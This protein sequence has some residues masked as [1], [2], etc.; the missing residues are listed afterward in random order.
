MISSSD[1]A[2]Q[3]SSINATSVILTLAFA[4]GVHKLMQ[5][6]K[7]RPEGLRIAIGQGIEAEGTTRLC[8]DCSKEG[9]EHP[10]ELFTRQ[11]CC[12]YWMCVDCRRMRQAKGFC[13]EC[14]TKYPAPYAYALDEVPACY[15]PA[16]KYFYNNDLARFYY[17]LGRIYAIGHHT[18]FVEIDCLPEYEPVRP[19]RLTFLRHLNPMDPKTA[20]KFLTLSAEYEYIPAQLALG[21]LYDAVYHDPSSAEKWYRRALGRGKDVSPLAF[22]RYGLFLEQQG[23][24]REAKMLFKDAAQCG[25]AHAQFEYARMILEGRSGDTGILSFLFPRQAAK[26]NHARR[27]EAVKWLCSASEKGFYFRSYILLAKTL[28][29]IAEEKHGRADIVGKSPLPRAFQML[30]LAKKHPQIDREVPRD[31]KEILK[32]IDDILDPYEEGVRRRCATCGE[33][34]TEA[35]PLI[36]CEFCGIMAYC[37]KLCRKKHYRDGHCFDCCGP[38]DLFRFNVNEVTSFDISTVVVTGSKKSLRRMVDDFT[39]EVMEG[40]DEDY[41]SEHLCRLMIKMRRNLEKY[42]A[43]KLQDNGKGTLRNRIKKF[44]EKYD[45]S[46]EYAEALDA[47]RLLGNRGAHKDEDGIQPLTHSEC[48][49]AVERFQD[50]RTAFASEGKHPNGQPARTAGEEEATPGTGDSAY[51]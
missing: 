7:S 48:Q 46:E 30:Y 21:D 6:R 27:V 49:E 41:D 15:G 12:G 4:S 22:T 19:S 3:F 24:Y 11:P 1:V 23:R 32:E 47:I 29:E 8:R 39:D 51:K 38:R 28:I 50:F 34:G 13:G 25:H 31:G 14:S 44:V 42:L 45:L 16:N 10:I 17:L 5:W 26:P 37:G 2:A 35:D 18:Y 36:D 43:E 9:K 33:S 20:A 40:E